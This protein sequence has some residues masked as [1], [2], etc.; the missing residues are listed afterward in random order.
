M[1]PEII[2][3]KEEI[4]KHPDLYFSKDEIEMKQNTEK[5]EYIFRGEP[6]VETPY[7][8]VTAEAGGELYEIKLKY[9]IHAE[10]RFAERW[11]ATKNEWEMICWGDVF[12]KR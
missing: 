12:Y 4:K 10:T 1:F 6:D 8:I 7:L 9:R 11:N 5:F 2:A 3:A